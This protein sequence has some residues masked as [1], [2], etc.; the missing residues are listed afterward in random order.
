MKFDKSITACFTGHRVVKNDFAV[1]QLDDSIENLIEKGYMFFLCGMAWGFDLLCFSR[2][3][4]KK[5]KYGYIVNV[6]CIPCPEQAEKY[7]AENKRIYEKLV[8]RADVRIMISDSYNDY[9]MK[10]RDRFMVDNSSI[11]VSYLYSSLGG[12]YYTTK[13]ASEKG[14]DIIYVK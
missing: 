3:L 8:S 2:L 4:E 10:E 9:C 7:S 13:Y 11:C 1:E 12:T 5:K 6:A 14:L